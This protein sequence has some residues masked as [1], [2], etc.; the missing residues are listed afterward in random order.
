MTEQLS[1]PAAATVQGRARGLPLASTDPDKFTA[2]RY[3]GVSRATVMRL[4]ARG[5]LEGFHVGAA[6]M[7]T[8]ASL[9]AYIERQRLAELERAYERAGVYDRG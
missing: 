3:L 8:V 5:E 9:D 6:A 7:I 2:A 1:L 4:R